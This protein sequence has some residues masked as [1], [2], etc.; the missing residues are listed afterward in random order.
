M[1]KISLL[2]GCLLLSGCTRHAAQAQVDYQYKQGQPATVAR[3]Q[4]KQLTAGTDLAL[5]KKVFFSPAPNYSLT[6]DTNDP[7]DLTD[8]T[9][10]SRQDDRVWFNK[11][12]VGWYLSP[13][14]SNGI[15]LMI[16]LG[17]VQPVGQIAIRVLG[18][19]EQ[20]SL[21]LPKS[22]EFLASADGKQY[23]SLQNLVQLNPAEANQADGK[24]GF[25]YPE[26]GKA[27]M[28]PLV[29]REPVMARYIAIR[30]IPANS[31]FTDQI[32]VLKAGAATPLKVL[33]SFPQAQVFTDGLAI[34]P[35][36]E[37]FVVTTNIDT[38]NWLT[39][40][41][42]TNLDPSKNQL[43]F[44]LELPDGLRVLPISQ[45]AFKEVPSTHPG[46]HGYEFS[47]AGKK[48]IGSIGP[49]WIAKDAAAKIPPDAK[50]LLTGIVEG[51]DSH[52]LQFPLKLVEIP[53][54]HAIKGLDV[55][56]AWMSDK[57]E[58]QWPNFLRD[59]HKMGFGY[60]STF[61][62]D[63][64]KNKDGSWNADAQKYLAFL[65]EARA[66]GYGII[67]NE[68]AFHV[69]WNTVQADEK[70]GK[71]SD[72]EADQLFTQIDGKRGKWMNILYRG[73]YFQNEMKRVA[74]LAALVQPDQV[75][76]DIEWWTQSVDESK[77]D[78]RV[79][80]AWKASGKSWDD[81]VTDIGTQVLGDLIS[82]TRNAVPNRKLTVGLYNSDPKNAIYNSIFG[83]NKIYPGIVDIAMPSLYIQGRADIVAERIRFDYDAMHTKQIIPWLSTGT[84]GEYDPKLTEPMVL[85]AI[86]NGSRGITYFW[87]G[88]F[89]PMDFY[90][91]S[92]AIS[93]LAP[94]G[95]LL[96]KGKPVSYKGDNA[97]LHYTAFAD[98]NEALVLVENF[99]GTSNTKVTLKSPVP[100][101]TKVLLDGK[102]LSLQNNAVS[103][104]VPPNEFR[105]VY[106]GK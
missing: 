42:N 92:K 51:K 10:T 64:G 58:Q 39:A 50:V 14:L 96:Q 28:V 23:Y 31:L 48:I 97:D 70:A 61:P 87:F 4:W 44:R 98:G 85:E 9:L 94:Y 34:L 13:G 56:L 1:N 25:Y 68:S 26:V 106:F 53:E 29:C 83:W 32:S 15:L 91:H 72:A 99:S 59:F 77:K 16:D 104:D 79:I 5:G 74:D 81:F 30:V 46:M 73:K 90:Y 93:E 17:S 18:G 69:M 63:F 66:D 6:T 65:K 95:T 71:I 82:A 27:F 57:T 86:L 54:T 12:A 19:H 78:P 75:Y 11:D 49:L 84:Y 60:V 89:D 38:P 33:S 100:S 20:D 24:T 76:F 47:Y 55:S 62:R 67:Y 21:D 8:G 35:R 105:M 103:I 88:D 36:H 40:L 80:A 2:L 22:A 101:T 41:D 3:E 7:Y 43:G 37:P 52:A 45:P 102:A